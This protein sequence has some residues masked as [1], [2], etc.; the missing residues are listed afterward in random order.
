MLAKSLYEIVKEVLVPYLELC[1]EI[2]ISSSDYVGCF[3]KLDSVANT[4]LPMN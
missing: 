4:V 1:V 3:K 2:P